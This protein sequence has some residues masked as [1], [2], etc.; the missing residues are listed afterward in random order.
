M[1]H[2]HPNHHSKQLKHLLPT[3]KLWKLRLYESWKLL[4][5]RS[6]TTQAMKF[7]IGSVQCFL[8]M[9][10]QNSFWLDKLNLLR[11]LTLAFLGISKNC[12]QSMLISVI[13]SWYN[14]MKVFALWNSHMKWIFSYVIGIL[15]RKIYE[16]FI[17]VWSFWVTLLIMAC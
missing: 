14:L 2:Q 7:L 9:A 12:L 15:K 10:L 16:L 11:L 4:S 6:L 5:L 3:L 1:I 8:I 17:G 13:V